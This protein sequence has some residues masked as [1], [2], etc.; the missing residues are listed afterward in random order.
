MTVIVG[1]D[2]HRASLAALRF[3]HDLAADLDVPLHVVHVVDQ[4]DTPVDPDA[5]D[6]T[7]QTD[8]HVRE[9]REQAQSLLAQVP[10]DWSYHSLHG[11]AADV[12]LALAEVE[13]AA[14][15]VLGQPEHGFGASVD[16]L[17]NGAIAR[18]LLRRSSRPIVVVPA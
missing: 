15:I 18:T 11:D 10:G 12:L 16:H 8:T 7:E 13:D 17:L 2:R 5:A 9:L 4:N 14:M 3:G 1:F 6:W